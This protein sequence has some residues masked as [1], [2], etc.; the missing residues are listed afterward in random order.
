MFTPPGSAEHPLLSATAAAVLVFPGASAIAYFRFTNKNLA[1]ALIVGV[2]C[3]VMTFY[4][5]IQKATAL[6]AER[7][8]PKPR[9]RVH[10]R[11]YSVFEALLILIAAGLMVTSAIYANWALVEPGLIFGGLGVAL[12]LLRWFGASHRNNYL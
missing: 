10:K 11:P 9:P 5:V 6:S 12:I 8:L 4:G 3:A 2:G 7:Q 1:L